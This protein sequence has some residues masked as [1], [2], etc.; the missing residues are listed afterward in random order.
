MTR[1]ARCTRVLACMASALALSSP[2][3]HAAWP[4]DKP[5]KLVVPFAAG[6]P[7]D[8]VARVVSQPLSELLGASV[9]IENRAGA[10][11]N[12]GIASV[13]RA[14]P[15]GY[16]LLVCSS[17]FMLNPSLFDNVPY[18]AI[19]DFDTGSKPGTP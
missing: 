13:A 9:V 8:I 16:T 6:G 18:D 1:T 4:N 5:I 3:A 2:T 12:I 15:D 17:A 19:A 14:D 10:G 11:G 7:P